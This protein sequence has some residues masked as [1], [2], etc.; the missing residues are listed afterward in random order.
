M[1]MHPYLMEKMATERVEGFRTEADHR[2]LVALARPGFAG[3]RTGW[4]QRVAS[5]F[6]T[7]FRPEPQ[8]CFC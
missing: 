1:E 3:A 5:T 2:R 7:L 8:P 4:A 6:A